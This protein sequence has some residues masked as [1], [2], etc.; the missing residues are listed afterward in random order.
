MLKY[1][2]LTFLA[3]VATQQ[4]ISN[5]IAHPECPHGYIKFA[6]GCVR[7]QPEKCPT[8]MINVSFFNYTI[9]E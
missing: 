4:T 8:G 6:H 5:K 2:F 1:Y 3:S 9:V 7:E